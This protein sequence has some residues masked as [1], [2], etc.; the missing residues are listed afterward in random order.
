MPAHEQDAV[1]QRRAENPWTQSWRGLES[2]LWLGD[3][4][5]WEVLG[6]SGLED[7]RLARLKREA[8]DV[9]RGKETEK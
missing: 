2:S 3:G 8:G 1:G 9:G 4:Q 6:P 5:G 7:S